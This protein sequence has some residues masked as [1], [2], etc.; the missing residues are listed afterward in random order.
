MEPLTFEITEA[1]VQC[2]GKSFHYKDPLAS[3]WRNCG[4]PSHLISQYRHEQKYPQARHI[5]AELA[6]SDEGRLVARKILTQLCQFK[7]IPDPNAPDPK[8]GLASLQALKALAQEQKLF[9]EE[10]RKASDERLRVAQEQAAAKQERAKRLETLKESY[11]E[12]V[13]MVNRQAA[14]YLLEDLLTDLFALSEIE[15]RKSYRAGTQ[16][17]DGH[18]NFDSFDY[19]VEAKWRKVPPD[20]QEIA[21]FKNK[22]ETK[23][24]ST[25]G[26]FVSIQG[27]RP[28]I[29]AQ[30]QGRDANIIFMDGMDLYHILDGRVSLVDA[31]KFKRDKAVQEG[32]VFA[33]LTDHF[34]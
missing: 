30:F 14:G 3:F 21:G 32:R 28:E 20:E 25:R 17:I 16:Q 7:K 12:G 29:I 24:T 2:I 4:V 34:V 6:E 5:L 10:Q 18:F 27:Y 23:L 31:L 11:M 13:S 33:S 9:V 1:I 22:V 15:Y 26:M 8:A 19:I